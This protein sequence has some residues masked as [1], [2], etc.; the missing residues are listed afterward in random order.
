MRKT[1]LATLLAAPLLTAQGAPTFEERLAA[2]EAA[3]DGRLGFDV[4]SQYFFRGIQQENQGIIFQPWIELNSR[5]WTGDNDDQSVDLVFGQ[6]NS[7][8]DGPTGTGGPG[9][10][11]YESRFFVGANAQL[12][13]RFQAGARL[14]FYS[15][16]NGAGFARGLSN[17]TELQLDVRF[18]DHGVLIEDFALNP[19]ATLA[20]ELNNQ[21]DGGS[22][23]GAY[24][25]LGVAPEFEIGSMGEAPVVLTVPA[26]IGLGLGGYYERPGTNGDDDF[27]GYL[28]VGGV[29]SAP[30]EFLPAGMGPWIGHAGLHALLLGD[31]NE[32]RNGSDSAELIFEFG[33]STFF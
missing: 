2:R 16:P 19:Y 29:V 17:I 30:M 12:G 10:V 6:W 13:E 27:F 9:G 28:Q 25:E 21:R 18:D 14:N 24:V 15:T 33:M 7:L 4:T 8:H 23:E 26:R 5:L 11:W 20:I 32:R 22:D 3:I 31:N 1:T